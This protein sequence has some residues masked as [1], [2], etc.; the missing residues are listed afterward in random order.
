M[1][2]FSIII[3][4]LILIT[5]AA[6]SKAGSPLQFPIEEV[7]LKNGLKVILVEEHKAPVATFQVWYRVGSRNEVSGKTGL[8]HMMEHMM[9]KGTPKHGKGEFSRLI[10]KNGGNSNAFTGQDYTAYF[11]NFSKDRLDLSLLLESDRMENLTLDP[12]EFRLERDVVKEERR[13]RTDDNPLD[14]LSELLNAEAFIAH[15]YHAPVIGWMTDIDHLT[16]ENVLNHYKKFY[17]PNNATLVIVGDI[18]PKSLLPKIK[19]SFEHIPPGE[20]PAAV[21]I[22]EPEQN[23]ER[24]FAVNKEAQMPA[25]MMGFRTPNFKDPDHF[26][27]TLLSTILSSGKSSRLYRTLVY[28]KKVALETGADYSDLT[29]DPSLFSIY[30]KPQ[31]GKSIEALEEAVW[32]EI[33]RLKDEPVSADELKKAKNQIETQFVLNRDSNF[34]VA[35]QLG[36]AESVGAGAHY[37]DSFLD[38]IRKVSPEDL[39]RTAKKYFLKERLTEGVLKPLASAK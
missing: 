13:M 6:V 30:A 29:A 26:P 36:M 27:L 17:L 8:S 25:F 10:A 14:Y 23:G 37:F 5:A 33:N 28:D 15:P 35:M 12:E 39:Q 7:V 19:E 1:R 9:F 24:R 11:E 18:D 21:E 31:E 16:R 20:A 38:G 22:V 4:A 34:F 3:S 2:Y 32:Q